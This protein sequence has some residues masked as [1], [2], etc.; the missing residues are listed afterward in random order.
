MSK[1]FFTRRLPFRWF[2]S[3]TSFGRGSGGDTASPGGDIRK[4]TETRRRFQNRYPDYAEGAA[5]SNL[6]PVNRAVLSERLARMS[7]VIKQHAG[8]T[9]ADSDGSLYV[10]PSGIGY[11]FYHKAVNYDSS[12]AEKLEDLTF[13]KNMIEVNLSFARHHRMSPGFLLGSSGLHAVAAA[14]YHALNDHAKAHEHAQK[15]GEM[16]RV[17][18]PLKVYSY[19]SDELLVGRSGYVMGA[20]WLNNVI[21]IQVIAKETLHA[22]CDAMV[23]SGSEYS[24]RHRSPCTLMYAY[25]GTE[26]LGAAHGLCSI[27]QMILTVPDYFQQTSESNK[28]SI[29]DSIDF[30]LGIQS[31]STFNFACAMDEIDPRNRGSNRRHPDDE[32]VH[33]CHGAPGTVYLMAKAYKVTG[34]RRYLESALRCGDC[35]WKSGLLKKGP[36]ICHGVAGSGYVFLLL[37]GLTGDPKHLHRANAFAEFMETGEFARGARTPDCQWSL[38]EGLAGT[39]CFLV[40]LAN[41]KSDGQFPFFENV[42]Q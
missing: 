12:E 15:F 8:G 7:R 9:E 19:G 31:Q 6:V 3:G 40:N 25:H 41:P 21:G 10:G 2:S 35:V 34:D 27:L 5:G 36:G 24:R 17:F 22:L 32:L 26:Y 13:A 18:L 33:W 1:G 14:V 16:A 30:L 38:Y 39:M 23:E 28:K 29:I 20:L 4:M 11:A 37:H 42:L